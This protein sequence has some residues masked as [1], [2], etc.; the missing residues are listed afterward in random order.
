MGSLV[1][2]YLLDE[3]SFIRLIGL[4]K[5]GVLHPV[6]APGTVKGLILGIWRFEIQIILG[7]WDKGKETI[8]DIG[9][10]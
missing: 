9:H 5:I 4:I 8:G 3:V 7:F 2:I 1:K 6:N 10:A